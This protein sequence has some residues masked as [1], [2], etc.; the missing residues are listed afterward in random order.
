MLYL[1]RHSCTLSP[2][3]LGGVRHAV[4]AVHVYLPHFEND[5]WVPNLALVN[6]QPVMTDQ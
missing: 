3:K 4:Y 2:H 6:F 1:M 5:S